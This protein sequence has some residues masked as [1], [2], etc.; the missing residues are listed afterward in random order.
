M[1]YFTITNTTAGQPTWALYAGNNEMVAW[2]GESFY[3]TSNA[4]RAAASFQAGASTARYDVYADQG[5][6]WRWRA[7][8]GSDKVASSGESFSSRTAA[9]QAADRVRVNA[10]TARLV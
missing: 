8:R 4:H 6:H 7:W 3:S 10:G 9:Q 2:A 1:W 5:G